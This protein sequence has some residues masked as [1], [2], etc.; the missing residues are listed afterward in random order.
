MLCQTYEPTTYA[1]MYWADINVCYMTPSWRD[2]PRPFPGSDCRLHAL[3][4]GPLAPFQCRRADPASTALRWPNR[5]VPN[6]TSLEPGTRCLFIRGNAL[7]I[8][9]AGVSS[10]KAVLAQV[11]W[12]ARAP[13]TGHALLEVVVSLRQ[14]ST[15]TCQ[16]QV[17]GELLSRAVA[18][19]PGKRG[20]YVKRQGPSFPKGAPDCRQRQVR[21]ERGASGGV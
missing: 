16:R 21:G 8:K 6:N 2:A 3:P 10:W 7:C 15:S 20:G 14:A 19:L 1:D 13:L 17:R 9:N 4:A 11:V 18:D 5:R 12:Q